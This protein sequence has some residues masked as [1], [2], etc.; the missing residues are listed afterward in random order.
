MNTCPGE[1]MIFDEFTASLDFTVPHTTC[2]RL[3]NALITN[4]TALVK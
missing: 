1:L 3:L 4:S 2:L